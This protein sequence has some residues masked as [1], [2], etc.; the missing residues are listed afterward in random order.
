V[1]LTPFITT[2]LI[3]AGR[4]TE[5]TGVRITAE[6][7]GNANLVTKK[8]IAIHQ[9]VTSAIHKAFPS[10]AIL[11]EESE[12]GYSLETADELWIL[13]P[14]DGTTNAAHGI[15]HYGISLAYRKD[16]VTKV[17]GV[18]D[19]PNK[20]LYMAESGNGAYK[21]DLL[22]GKQTALQVNDT[23]LKNAL[24]STSMPYKREDFI[25]NSSLIDKTNQ[26]GARLLML[27]STVI[28]ASYVAEGK[29]SLY[30]DQGL[31][32]WDIAAVALIVE[33]A[34]GVATNTEG[35]LDI[36]N[37]GMFVCGG[38]NTVNEFLFLIGT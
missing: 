11:S 36:F 20:T 23:G 26:A 17:G 12:E 29:L 18:L 16:G 3:D 24:I 21:K 34:G 25:L 8:D 19:I 30:F 31:K 38:K 9:F 6:K 33:E 35:K 32:P 22:T 5:G 13:D 37:P 28:V 10:H 2:T 14:L 4:T 27:G 1:E 7:E 15:P